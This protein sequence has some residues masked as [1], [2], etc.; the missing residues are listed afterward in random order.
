MSRHILK[1]SLFTGSKGSMVGY[2]EAI[3]WDGLFIK[4]NFV[5]IRTI[6]YGQGL[7]YSLSIE[8]L[9][10]QDLDGLQSILTRKIPIYLEFSMT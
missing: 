7:K 5:D 1:R 6:Q 3:Y 10:H 2:L 9:P 8:K 4:N